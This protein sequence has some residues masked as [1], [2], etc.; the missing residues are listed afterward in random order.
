MPSYNRVLCCSD[1][2]ELWPLALLAV[3]FKIWILCGSAASMLQHCVQEWRNKE[4]LF[5][6]SSS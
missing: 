6:N 2:A 4:M 3:N 1:S 5:W